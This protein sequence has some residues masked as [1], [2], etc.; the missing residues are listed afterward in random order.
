MY[1]CGNKAGDNRASCMYK[2][3]FLCERDLSQLHQSP[4]R[5]VRGE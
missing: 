1:L 5:I 3:L 4:A 2:G